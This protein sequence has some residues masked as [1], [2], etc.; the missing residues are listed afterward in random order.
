MSQTTL[1]AAV[2]AKIGA[3]K[4]KALSEAKIKSLVESKNLA[5]FVSQLR[6]T[7]YQ[8]QIAKLP[9]PLTSRKLE[10]AFNENLVEAYVKMIKNSPKRAADF[11]SIYV[12]RFEVENIKTLIK[13]INGEMGVEEK[14]ARIYF[15]VEDFLGKRAMLEE[16]AKA[17]TLRQMQNSIKDSLYTSALSR[18]MQSYEENGSTSTF[19]IFL[20]KVFYD[21]LHDAYEQV[22]RSQRNHVRFY[23]ATENDSFTILTSLRAKTLNYD[24]SWLRNVVPPKNF[25]LTSETVDALVM[26]ADFETALKIATETFYGKLFTKAPSA[27]E[28]LAAAEKAFKRWMFKHAK[29]A[30]VGEIFNVGAPLSFMILKEAEVRNLIAASAGVEDGVS[31]EYIQSQMLL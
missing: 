30:T 16:A 31:T 25:K 7:S 9:P 26:A 10:R 1:Y 8:A 18:G 23:A 11:L 13:A 20:D 17:T 28:T 14:L 19:D 22:P 21:A 24:A 12:L 6:D 15:S 27:E 3:E 29:A 2:F 5:S 4:S